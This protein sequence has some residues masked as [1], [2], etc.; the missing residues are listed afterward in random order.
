MKTF[1]RTALLICLTM[2]VSQTAP[3][4]TDSGNTLALDIVSAKTPA[5]K[6]AII[7]NAIGVLYYFRYLK[8]TEMNDT[9]TNGNR[10]VYISAVE[11]SSDMVVSFAVIKP[12]SLKTLDNDPKSKIGSCIGATGR[13]ES[14]GK[15]APNTIV[16]NPVIVN[17]KDKDRPV[18]GKELLYE[19]D[20][21]ARM[22][23]DTSSG[24]S[25]KIPAK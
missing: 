7:K 1:I 18:R 21:N 22:G 4:I 17:H 24:K 12:V 8:I 13:I 10:V 5:E 16:I 6:S 14:I 19:I 2:L 3:A 23:T 11:P 20:P 15:K 9:M 25:I